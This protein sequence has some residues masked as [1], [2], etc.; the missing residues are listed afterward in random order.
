MSLNVPAARQ[1]NTR[2]YARLNRTSS[3]LEGSTRCHVIC[4]RVESAPA[5]MDRCRKC[6]NEGD[7]DA[8][9]VVHGFTLFLA[10]L[11]AK[12]NRSGI[13]TVVAWVGRRKV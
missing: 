12:L 1:A 5:P 11:A 2:E 13:G 8:K 10:I 4:W 6:S 3:W 7:T 9:E